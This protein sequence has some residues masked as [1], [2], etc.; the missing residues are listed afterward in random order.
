M[1]SAAGRGGPA[2]R[3]ACPMSVLD[4]VLQSEIDAHRQTLAPIE[5][6]TRAL[7][8]KGALLG[9]KLNLS[10]A[11]FRTKQ[12]NGRPAGLPR[13]RRRL[14]HGRQRKV[15]GH[16]GANERPEGA[17]PAGQH[18][19]DAAV[20][21]RRRRHGRAHRCPASHPQERHHVPIQR[22]PAAGG[23]RERE[24]ATEDVSGRWR[25]RDSR[26]TGTWPACTGTRAFTRRRAMAAQACA[27]SIDAP[28]RNGRP[29][30]HPATVTHAC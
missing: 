16:R 19:C 3:H 30:M 12:D 10:G 9:G 17:Q 23:G 8:L 14:L 24:P 11:L 20:G 6:K 26:T 27:G 22:D 2:C 21:L 29:R 1:A 4:A 28:A 5:G 7:G 18:R 25:R 15:A 13:R